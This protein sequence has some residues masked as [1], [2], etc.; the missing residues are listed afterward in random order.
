MVH[1]GPR[2]AAAMA[3]WPELAGALRGRGVTREK[4]D[5]G[6]AA[7]GLTRGGSRRAEVAG[8][9]QAT[10]SA[11]RQATAAAASW[12]RRQG[13]EKGEGGVDG[14]KAKPVTLKIGCNMFVHALYGE[15]NEVPNVKFAGILFCVAGVSM[16]AFYSKKQ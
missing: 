11:Q 8:D 5:G 14:G 4:G 6:G 15:T 16:L 3:V 7:R 12:A 2:T 1:G 10:A 13:R 9:G